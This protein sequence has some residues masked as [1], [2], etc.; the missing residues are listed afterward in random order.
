MEWF[1]KSRLFDLARQGQRLTHIA[2]VIPLTFFFAIIAQFGVIPVLVGM[3]VLYGA[4]S[5]SNTGSLLGFSPFLAGFWESLL[6]ITSFV[7]IYFILWLWLRLFEKRPFWTLGY[8]VKNSLAQY[9]RGFLIGA[10]M[11]GGAVGIL[12]ITGGVSF[13]KGVATQQGFAALGGVFVVLIGWIVQGGAEEALIRGWALPVIGARYK[14]WIEL[15]VW[16][17]ELVVEVELFFWCSQTS[18]L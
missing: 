16:F 18:G 3:R 6:L 9:G 7:L 1:I 13:E 10:L 8:E 17:V 11:F 12:A 15:F 2:A 5:L 4:D 14:P